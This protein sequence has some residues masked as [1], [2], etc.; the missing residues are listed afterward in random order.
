MPGGYGLPVSALTLSSTLGSGHSA[1]P[2][3][4]I[5]RTAWWAVASMALFAPRDVAS[6]SGLRCLL[7]AGESGVGIQEK[8]Q[9]PGARA[10]IAQ[11]STAGTKNHCST[12]ILTHQSAVEPVTNWACANDITEDHF[13]GFTTPFIEPDGGVTSTSTRP[14]TSPSSTSSTSPSTGGSDP[15]ATRASTPSNP[16]NS[17][18][19]ASSSSGLGSATDTGGQSQSNSGGITNNLGAII[20]GVVGCVAILCGFGLATV[21]LVRRSR[22]GN[23]NMAVADKPPSVDASSSRRGSDSDVPGLKPELEARGRSELSGRGPAAYDT[24]SRRPNYPPMTPVELPVNGA[25]L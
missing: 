2:P 9:G 6:L 22:S 4:A 15:A 20:G 23:R 11:L 21:W 5:H 8:K 12:A 19:P 7:S 1:R 13:M 10:D 14:T 16:P 24:A 3:L 18:N 25:W 17:T